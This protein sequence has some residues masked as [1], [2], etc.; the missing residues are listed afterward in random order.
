MNN[1][2]AKLDTFGAAIDRVADHV[3]NLELAATE[4]GQRIDRLEGQVSD[5]QANA[6]TPEQYAKIDALT[7]KLL[8]ILPV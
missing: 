4:A 8:A 6:V 5:L 1:L 3:A 2:D 7:A